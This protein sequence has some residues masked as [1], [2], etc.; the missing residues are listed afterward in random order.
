[1]AEEAEEV[2]AVAEEDGTLD[3]DE[4]VPSNA[5]VGTVSVAAISAELDGGADGLAGAGGRDEA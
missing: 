1:M 3:S 4:H 2:A 5:A